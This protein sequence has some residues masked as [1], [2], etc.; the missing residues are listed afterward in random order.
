MTLD[1]YLS[2]KQLSQATF[3]RLVGSTP[4]TI[5]RVRSGKRFPGRALA[6]RI[7]QETKG[8]VTVQDLLFVDHGEDNAQKSDAS[9]S[10][11]SKEFTQ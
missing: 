10:R 4:S 9:S 5:S 3:A 8:L 1:D 7:H 11:K 6:K 2:S